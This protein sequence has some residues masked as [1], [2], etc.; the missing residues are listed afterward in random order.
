MVGECI[1]F[2]VIYGEELLREKRVLERV[3]GSRVLGRFY[4]GGS[5]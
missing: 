2:R 4:G 5:F 3:L 1:W